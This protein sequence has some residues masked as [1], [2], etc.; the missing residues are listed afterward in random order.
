MRS[1]KT[2][3]RVLIGVGLIVA[4]TAHADFCKPGKACFN[5]Q[6]EPKE[7]SSAD[8]CEAKLTSFFGPA[9]A[10]CGIMTHDINCDASNAKTSWYFRVSTADLDLETQDKYRHT[11]CPDSV[12]TEADCVKYGLDILKNSAHAQQVMKQTNYKFGIACQQDE[13]PDT[14]SYHC[15][16]PSSLCTDA[17]VNGDHQPTDPYYTTKYRCDENMD[18]M[19]LAKDGSITRYLTEAPGLPAPGTEA[20]VFCTPKVLIGP[21]SRGSQGGTTNKA[22]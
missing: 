1:S 7:V 2:D 12:R 8:Q 14:A 18:R 13:V 22:N 3:F 21:G 11:Q 4:S 19:I 17:S 16:V 6:C 9:A 5:Y 20:T 10:A 15:S